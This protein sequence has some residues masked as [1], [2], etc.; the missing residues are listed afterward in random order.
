LLRG[1][2]AKCPAGIPQKRNFRAS[3]KSRGELTVL[4]ITPNEEGV[5][6]FDPGFPKF[7]WLN[8]L[9]NSTRSSSRMGSRITNAL[10]TA[11][12]VFQNPGP[13]TKFL[14]TFPK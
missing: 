13:V 6:T 10:A 11:R 7:G 3:C 2:G 5:E 9:K 1:P 4:E 14:G 8:R 12:S